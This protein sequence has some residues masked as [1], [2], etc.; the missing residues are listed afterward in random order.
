MRNIVGSID[1]IPSRNPGEASPARTLT[2]A[3]AM[4][5]VLAL[6][7]KQVAAA[8]FAAQLGNPTVNSG[9][10]SGTPTTDTINVT[11]P[12]A[13]LTW[14]PSDTN[15]GAGAIDFLPSGETV[16][17]NGPGN[18]NYTILNR[19]LPT[20]NAVG[21]SVA[22]NGTVTANDGGR[23]WF[24]TPNGLLVGS[25]A[26]FNVGGLLLT[27]G[28]PSTAGTISPSA[29][30]GMNSGG[31]A[32]SVT[33]SSG[34][35]IN[36]NAASGGAYVAVVAPVIQQ[37][38]TVT[39]DGSAAYVAG[40]QV[41]L[42]I[43]SGLFDIVVPMGSDSAVQHNGTTQWRDS[44][45]GSFA[46]QIYLVSVPKNSAVT[47][48]LN[49]AGLGFDTAVAASRAADGSIVLSGGFNISS[50]NQNFIGT[51][52]PTTSQ[53]ADININ[54]GNFRGDV[55]AYSTQNTYAASTTGTAQ[56]SGDAYLYGI[57][58]AHIAARQ[59]GVTLNVG[60]KATVDSTRAFS[61]DGSPVIA[62]TS[63]AY[64]E[65]GGTLSITG[66][67]DVLANAVGFRPLGGNQ[68]N[69]A[70]APAQGGNATL[71]ANDGNISIGGNVRVLSAAAPGSFG[72]PDT[73]FAAMAATG[74]TS[75]VLAN[76]NSQL[77]I[78]G[79]LTI[80]A[81]GVAANGTGTGGVGTGG[82]VN[83]SNQNASNITIG[84]G[85]S[86]L[87]VGI[88][89]NNDSGSASAGIGG[90]IS[91]NGGIGATG[92]IA[93]NGGGLF[94]R[95]DA[96]GGTATG[97]GGD[98]GAGTAGQVG[99]YLNGSTTTISGGLEMTANG[100][101]GDGG[102]SSAGS[103]GAGSGGRVILS[104]NPGTLNVT[105]GDLRLGANAS[106]GDGYTNGGNALYAAGASGNPFDSQD[107]ARGYIQIGMSG[108]SGS[109]N[110]SGSN[111][112]LEASAQAG[113]G[114]NGASGNASAGN[115]VIASPVGSASLAGG[116][117]S[118]FTLNVDGRAGVGSEGSSTGGNAT[119][120]RLGLFTSNG[121]TLSLPYVDATFE[122]F[123]GGSSTA[124]PAG[125]ATGGNLNISATGSNGITIA[126]MNA[127]LNATGGYRD[128]GTGG[129]GTGGNANI[130]LNGTGSS[131]HL[132]FSDV[133][134]IGA[135]GFGGDGNGTTGNGGAGNGGNISVSIGI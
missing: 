45:S 53:L 101:G 111:A 131:P 1:P 94:A 133:L 115:M 57:T 14:N 18:A 82:N 112:Y 105:N 73:P 51:R 27:T 64:T 54:G 134:E 83:L 42:T 123:A 113:E 97:S 4:A 19:I 16:T 66:D 109:I 81:S 2:S 26:V 102:F 6:P 106:G 11:S 31:V 93:V 72:P 12:T 25:T 30:I 80:G 24:Y 65:N 86:L 125:V 71:H 17:F 67:L 124:N 70:F 98:G 104:T 37:S 34:A 44:T 90:N 47:M 52:A 88:G 116:S 46:R 32:N 28:D 119:G 129:A 122:A 79:D 118:G 55:I 61:P 74:G 35:V 100:D 8:G 92:T 23:V 22:L 95:A 130:F 50:T 56:F 85:L 99:I 7:A 114:F 77:T 91:V 58:N 3:F 15:S 39:V 43:N 126:G 107:P 5:T 41:N 75:S 108:G 33:I 10:F 60:G 96:I 62:G 76:N 132:S 68:S 63:R 21:R 120:G 110:H 87:A 127:N 9:T 128:N 117:G 36:A 29:A 20:D 40:Q 59:N 84:T 69:Y 48:A 38:G 13:V 121:G 89:A 103:G 49:P 78:T 135:T